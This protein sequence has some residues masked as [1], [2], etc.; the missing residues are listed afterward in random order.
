[1]FVFIYTTCGRFHGIYNSK[2]QW[3]LLRQKA[4]MIK[5]SSVFLRVTKTVSKHINEILT[6]NR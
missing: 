6:N 4:D 3:L 5:E 2:R 1:M